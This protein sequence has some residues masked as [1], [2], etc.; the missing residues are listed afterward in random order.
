MEEGKRRE[1]GERGTEFKISRDRVTGTSAKA[2]LSL[3][4]IKAKLY[5]RAAGKARKR[6]GEAL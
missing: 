2:F 5:N 4:R 3:K 6:R 1:E